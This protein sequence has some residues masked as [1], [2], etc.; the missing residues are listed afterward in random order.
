MS[1]TVIDVQQDPT[2]PSNADKLQAA[3]GFLFAGDLHLSSRAPSRR[4]PGYME[5]GLDK[6]EQMVEIAN[7]RR[8]ILVLSGDIFHKAKEQSELLKTRLLRILGRCWAVVESNVGNHDMNGFTLGDDDTL[9]VIGEPNKP[10]RLH[11]TS[12]SGIEYQIGSRRFGLGFTPHGQKIPNN[13]RAVFPK[14]DFIIWSTH[15]DLAF[16]GVYPGAVELFP[17]EGCQLVV[18]G[19]MHLYKTPVQAGGTMWCN[20]G[21]VMRTAIDAL[22]HE[23][24]CWALTPESGLERIPLIYTADA[25]DLTGKLVD[26][27]DHEAFIDAAASSVFLDLLEAS[28]DDVTPATAD[29]VLVLEALMTKMEDT[30]ARPEIRVMALDLHRRCVEKNSA[31]QR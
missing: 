18:N 14:A 12:G 1:A 22:D 26:E 16:D 7:E 28:R 31:F 6:L 8:L 11:K 20:F 5:A 9:A 10:L 17:I 19:H 27:A 25:F 13:V 23:P 3:D 29:G 24:C 30:S 15:H 2:L 21:S 4:R